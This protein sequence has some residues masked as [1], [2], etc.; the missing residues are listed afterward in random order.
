MVSYVEQAILRVKDESTA[1]IKKIN[2]QI[3][4]LI[5]T[6]KKADKLKIDIAGLDK[7]AKEVRGLVTALKSLPA[8][9]TISLRIKQNGQSIQNQAKGIGA[10][11]K[12]LDDKSVK[13]PV[14][15]PGLT[16][17]LS[18]MRALNALINSV[19][20]KRVTGRGES[21]LAPAISGAE[22]R[23]GVISLDIKPLS[24]LFTNFIVSLGNTMQNAVQ[25]G[26][27]T[28]TSELDVAITRLKL[29]G[30]SDQK[31]SQVSAGAA[32]ISDVSPVVGRGAAIKIIS[33]ILPTTQFDIASAIEVSKQ[34]SEIIS[35]QVAQGASVEQA[36]EG[37]FKFSKA[38]EQ[39]GQ[40]TDAG[41]KIDPAKLEGFF[42]TIKMSSIAIGKEFT[43]DFVQQFIKY[44]RSTKY[45]LDREGLMTGFI[46]AEE[47][48]AS[49]AGVGINQA[50]KQISGQRLQKKH[51][52]RLIELGLITEGSVKV[53]DLE[54]KTINEVVAAG[55]IDESGLRKSPLDFITKNV[56]PKML[57][58]GINTS[59][60][61][62]VSKFVGGI[63]GDRTAE[64]ITN[65][66]VNRQKEIK[67]LIDAASKFDISDENFNKIFSES[68]LVA[69]AKISQ[70]FTSLL[71]EIGN[72]FKKILIP[73]MNL[74]A[75]AMQNLTNFIYGADG[76]GSAIRAGAVVAGGALGASKLI[77]LF[78]PLGA[79]GRRL[80]TSAGLLN[81]AARALITAA[82]AQGGADLPDADGNR[83]RRGSVR[84]KPRI[85]AIGN[86]ALPAAIAGL[87]ANE[88]F[89][90]G[91]KNYFDG[92][93]E[94][95]DA[96]LTR[97]IQAAQQASMAALKISDQQGPAA[98]QADVLRRE[99]ELSGLSGIF[100]SL[101]PGIRGALKDEL[102]I[103]R[104]ELNAPRNPANPT[105]A[106]G[107][108][109]FSSIGEELATLRAV[110]ENRAVDFSNAAANFGMV[111]GNTTAAMQQTF[112]TGAMQLNEVGV[113]IGNAANQFAPIVGNGL[114]AYAGQIGAQMAAAFSSAVGPISV[115]ARVTTDAP[116]LDTGAALP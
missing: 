101:I 96:K 70:Q 5:A 4:D 1:P 100:N 22:I 55:S 111:F 14:V 27:K 87:A 45:T 26:F 57:E 74:L 67:S 116:R 68:I 106:A 9:K 23:N 88:G 44:A 29:F 46:L 35:L 91:V 12:A 21:S 69:N 85:P 50:V 90:N 61:T 24:A 76:Q 54:G 93:I 107:Q 2:A 65:A 114:L 42:D 36:I 79:A 37:A 104:A 8:S 97:S 63:L 64:D 78:S 58:L 28:G 60:P 102:A 30:L 32:A 10:Q 89:L 48:G 113:T 83:N 94:K 3:K 7:T 17:A 49:S 38:A 6:A 43:A 33:E 40:V 84:P 31:I 71:G 105:Y 34:L 92:E 15:M 19:N 86:L 11:I 72:S 110:D 25:N 80:N 98:L 95:R 20:Q 16:K 66:I 39:T 59:D 112:S 52:A 53:G 109:G 77:S 103:A 81:T 41:G 62:Q 18:D 51:L 13:V 47:V 115:N 108:T 99:S 82:G 56:I 75:S 73:P